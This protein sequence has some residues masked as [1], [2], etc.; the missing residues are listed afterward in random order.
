M[1]I[2]NNITNIESNYREISGTLEICVNNS[3]HQVCGN[4]DA[5]VDVSTLTDLACR[6][7]EYTGIKNGNVTQFALIF[8]ICHL[9]GSSYSLSYPSSSSVID[10]ASCPNS[11]LFSLI[12]CEFSTTDS[13]S[14]VDM[15][16]FDSRIDITCRRGKMNTVE[17]H[18][19]D[20]HLIISSCYCVFFST[21]I[22]CNEGAIRLSNQISIGDF[23]FGDGIS[24]FLE[25]C[26][27]GTYSSVCAND[28]FSS[29]DLD[30]VVSVACS[31]LGYPSAQR[32]LL[33]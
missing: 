12:Q 27:N 32:Q 9:D 13:G 30:T 17:D 21:E 23:G 5:D 20:V 26:V 31:Q 19:L 25:I 24:G 22:G 16:S 6:A 2:N 10:Y 1:R 14:C 3:F 15:N 33:K 18:C 28:S 11:F 8:L 4:G 7:I 29:F